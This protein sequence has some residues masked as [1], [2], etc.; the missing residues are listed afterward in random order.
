MLSKIYQNLIVLLNYV[1]IILIV[2]VLHF[3]IQIPATSSLPRAIANSTAGNTIRILLLLSVV[4]ITMLCYSYKSIS[5]FSENQKIKRTIKNITVSK[6]DIISISI[7]GLVDL[8]SILG[9]I[10]IN[11]RPQSA[12][13]QNGFFIIVLTLITTVCTQPFL[14]ELLYRGILLGSLENRSKVLALVVSSFIFSYIHVYD[15]QQVI[16][17]H[18]IGGFIYGLTF[19]KTKKLYPSIVLHSVHNLIILVLICGA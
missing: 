2:T 13:W 11:G 12:L 3:L 18:L 16:N 14:E 8:A 5:L 6:N 1:R 7:F 17:F 19:L 15:F 10:F 9:Y 4:P